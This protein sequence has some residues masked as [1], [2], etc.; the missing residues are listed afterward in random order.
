MQAGPG[1]SPHDPG[2]SIWEAT[3]EL[4]AA[5]QD[6]VLGRVELLRTEISHDVQQVLIAAG[7]VAAGSALGVFG[8]V[9]AM[10]ALVALLSRATS[11]DV[12]LAVV[13]LPH[14]VGGLALAFAATRKLRERELAPPQREAPHG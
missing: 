7:M 1:P 2:I 14:L 8:W 6:V 9:L 10:G 12:A 13:G 4:V 5:G 3:A 11:V